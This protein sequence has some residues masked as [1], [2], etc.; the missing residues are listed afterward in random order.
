MLFQ[1]LMFSMLFLYLVLIGSFFIGF[2][3]MP[4]FLEKEMVPRTGFS[5]VVVYRNEAENLPELLN[6]IVALD[7]PRELFE[8]FLVNDHSEDASVGICER[9]AKDF[10]EIRFQLLNAESSLS[11]KKDAIF[12]AAGKARF[13]YLAITDA[14]C[15]LPSQWLRN[16]DQLLQEESPVLI[17][18]PVGFRHA[19][20]ASFSEAFE[21]IDFLSLQGSTIGGFGMNKPFM[22]NSANLC[23]RKSAYL[24]L[25]QQRR[26]LGIA[27]GDDVFLLQH[28]LQHQ[29][30]V[31]FVKSEKSIVQTGFQKSFQQL[32]WQ[33]VRWAAKTSAYPDAFGKIV[34]IV[35]FFTNLM[36]VI[37]FFLAVL[38]LWNFQLVFGMILAKFLVDFLLIAVTSKFFGRKAVLASYWW[39]AVIYPFF[40]TAVALRSVFGGYY[41]KGRPF[42]R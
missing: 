22:C 19:M 9:Y 28:F 38:Q 12:L 34:A 24:H 18:G 32:F 37:W 40:S 39:A 21:E 17:A 14:D 10:P 25:Q 3:K 36:T 6:S 29:L 31:S 27:S 5:L 11:P 30:P 41:W 2:R 35:V 20:S 7:Y 15:L 23:Y 42:K 26:D 13:E 1:I 16:F 33:R 4:V 8:V